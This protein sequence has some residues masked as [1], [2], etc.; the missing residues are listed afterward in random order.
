MS[1]LLAIG[2]INILRSVLIA[3]L[4]I[5]VLVLLR[6]Y[7]VWCAWFTQIVIAV[8]AGKNIPCIRIADV[9][10]HVWIMSSFCVLKTFSA[11]WTSKICYKKSYW[12]Y[13][14]LMLR[15]LRLNW[16]SE[17]LVLIVLGW[18][19]LTQGLILLR[20]VLRCCIRGIDHVLA[21]IML[22]DHMVMMLLG[23]LN[24]LMWV[25]KFIFFFN[26]PLT[27]AN[28]TTAATKTKETRTKVF[29][30]LLLFRFSVVR[31]F[32]VVW[33]ATITF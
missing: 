32:V 6:L 26:E 28:A 13:H 4:M 20:W 27:R 18:N 30:R 8:L 5:Y 22:R 21:R 15:I 19:R 31:V 23:Y 12:H 17:R 24:L 10:V 2:L 33:A 29:H 11:S 7:L 16:L 9:T 14:R 25:N 1:S 3:V